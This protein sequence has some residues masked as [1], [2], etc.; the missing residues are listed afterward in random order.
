MPGIDPLAAI[1][2]PAIRPVTT[3]VESIV[4]PGSVAV[5]TTVDPIA[6]PVEATRQLVPTGPLGAFRSR[7]QPCVDS[8]TLGIAPRLEAITAVVESLI[9]A[10]AALV[11]AVFDTIAAGINPIRSIRALIGSRHD[12]RENSG[13][14]QYLCHSF[15][16]SNSLV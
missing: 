15:H 11:E 12:G 4:D 3:V 5:E 6:L 10:I 7:V 8:I 1:I 9:G 2:Q 13:D 16:L 14:E